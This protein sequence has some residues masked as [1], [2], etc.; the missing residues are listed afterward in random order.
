MSGDINGR[1]GKTVWIS[2]RNM[3]SDHVYERDCGGKCQLETVWDEN[4]E[5]G[6]PH[7][8]GKRLGTGA[9][10]EKSVIFRVGETMCL[11]CGMRASENPKGWGQDECGFERPK[12]SWVSPEGQIEEWKEK[13]ETGWEEGNCSWDR[14]ARGKTCRYE[15]WW[16]TERWRYY[17]LVFSIGRNFLDY[18][19]EGSRGKEE[20][21]MKSW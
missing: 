1:W 15:L 7:R 20:H 6:M 4:C 3:I 9:E 2:V 12:Q 13:E 19:W 14:N 10:E 18:M 17:V 16:K 8:D 21:W 11:F 5:S